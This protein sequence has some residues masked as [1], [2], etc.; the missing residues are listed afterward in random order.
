M[1]HT[2]YD[3]VCPV[4][5]RR[6]DA[7]S[8]GSRAR[9]WRPPQFFR[10]D[11]GRAFRSW[12]R[13]AR[14]I[15][16]NRGAVTGHQGVTPGGSGLRDETAGPSPG[17]PEPAARKVVRASLKRSAGEYYDD[18]DIDLARRA[19][20]ALWAL[21]AAYTAAVLATH[22]TVAAFGWLAVL[23]AASAVLAVRLRVTGDR[24]P[25]ITGRDL[26]LA[27]YVG[28][29][30]LALAQWLGDGEPALMNGLLLA[31]IFASA[32]QPP[33]RATLVLVAVG[34]LAVAPLLYGSMRGERPIAVAAEILLWWGLAILAMLWTARTR[35]LRQQLQRERQRAHELA[36]E[37]A[38]AARTGETVGV[39]LVDVDRFKS[40]NDVHGHAAGDACL[41]AVGEALLGAVR[42][43]DSCFRWGGD[44]F[45]VLLPAT[46]LVAT[47]EAA[48]RAAVSVADRRAPDGAPMSASIG[49][50]ELRG[51]MTVDEVFAAADADLL[52]AKAARRAASP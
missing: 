49:C 23:G 6:F 10:V 17:S 2:E 41:R 29:T 43:A 16:G 31:A 1:G 51:D 47:R 32:T 28:I 36:H 24:V 18:L 20:A 48:A 21:A 40:I 44:E 30:L 35:A 45:V 7:G 14:V 9:S 38:R 8:G 11:E 4:P 39:L 19:G 37:A 34:A 13:P 25:A 46:D 42:A 27:T 26:L 52:A 50:A 5:P 15:P 3:E 22:A 12:P 33:R